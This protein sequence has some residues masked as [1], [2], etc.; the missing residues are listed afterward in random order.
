[1]TYFNPA[2]Y[3]KENLR[4]RDRKELEYYQEVFNNVITNSQTDFCNADFGGNSP[5]M[6]NI[7]NEVIQSFCEAL[8]TDLGYAMQEQVVG[9]IDNYEDDSVE[10]RE[11]YTTF[12]YNKEDQES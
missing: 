10:E 4:S 5:T 11:E 8:R 7:L 1:M 9:I 6:Q 12:L 2:I 3:N